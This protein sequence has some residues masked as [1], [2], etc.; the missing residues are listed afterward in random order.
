[1]LAQALSPKR[2]AYPG[3]RLVPTQV[4]Q[5]GLETMFQY[6]K[7]HVWLRNNVT[8]WQASCAKATSAKVCQTRRTNALERFMEKD[9]F[10]IRNWLVW[11]LDAVESQGLQEI[12]ETGCAYPVC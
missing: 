6:S 5:H 11:F 1:M 4:K 9:G 3:G 8:I 7:P 10:I 12:Q 2:Q